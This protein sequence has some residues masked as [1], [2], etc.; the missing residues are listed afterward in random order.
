MKEKNYKPV[1]SLVLLKAFSISAA[2]NYNGQ[3]LNAQMSDFHLWIT[4]ENY[5]A[6]ICSP[7]NRYDLG[8]ITDIQWPPPCVANT[9]TVN[10]DEGQIWWGGQLCSRWRTAQV[11]TIPASVMNALPCIWEVEARV[12]PRWGVRREKSGYY[13]LTRWIDKYSLLSFLLRG[14]IVQ[15]NL[16]GALYGKVALH[17]S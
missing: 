15:N 10:K 5:M 7:F 8:A 17:G 1:G 11:K 13:S 2:S 4:F 6:T 12:A 3:K 16:I 14:E 9:S